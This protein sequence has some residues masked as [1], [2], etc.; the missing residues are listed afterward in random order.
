MRD[1]SEK[2]HLNVVLRGSGHHEAAWKHS[3]A[4]PL[5][6]LSLEYYAE[7]VR[8][9]ERGLFDAAFIADS[10]AIAGPA[11]RL[12]PITLVSALAALTRH[13]GFIATVDTS[14]HEPYHVAR[15]FASLDHISGGR[16]AWN[17]VTSSHSV[18]ERFLAKEYPEPSVR[19]EIAGEFVE[20]V[21]LLWD[22]WEHEGDELDLSA[23]EPFSRSKPREIRFDGQHLKLQG[24]L[25]V[26]RP[27]QGHPVIVQAGASNPGIEL[28]A[29]TADVV[30]CAQQT[31]AE[32]KRF[33]ADVKSRM[34]RYGRQ[35]KQLLVIP[36][37]APIVADTEAEAKEI[38]RE[39]GAL[40]NERSLLA[41][42]S[43]WFAVD[44]NDYD[45][46]DPVP[47]DK[48]IPY[49]Q[50]TSGITSRSA[51]YME[52]ARA[53]GMTLRQLAARSAA[54]HGHMTVTG[55]AIQVADRMESWF[56]ERGADGFNLM[57]HL[58]PAGLEAFVAKVVPE[59]QNRG[60]FREAYEGE[61]LRDRLG[62]KHVEN[63]LKSRTEGGLA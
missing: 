29:R 60:L 48:A 53:E 38:E 6:D 46:D 3:Q 62:L 12:E 32:A 25:N 19:Y 11:R 52:A 7:I 59:L 41:K 56:R 13:L 55:S 54:G 22:S 47:L 57:P 28:A 15:K 1:T 50:L 40:A 21:K 16:S 33:Y 63:A 42:L 27:P 8:I 26:Q 4:K 31:L 49:R 35:T 10:Y 61:T 18:A 51:V 43:E 58:F 45:L 5:Q 30:F 2:L 36:G 39:F 44:L 23:D 9:A 24:P 17:V 20:A 14:Y 37:L 34:S